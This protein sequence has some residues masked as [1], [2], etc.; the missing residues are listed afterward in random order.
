MRL[1]ESLRD[2]NDLTIGF[3]RSEIDGRTYGHRSKIPGFLYRAKH[4][5]VILIGIAEQFIMIQFYN[6]R[7]FM[8][9]FS[10]HHTEASN[11]ACYC[12]TAPL[13][14]QVN[15][16]TRIK[17]HR[18]CTKRGTGTVFNTLVDW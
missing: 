18:V 15:N 17:I 10:R 12:I 14:G 9:I 2:C 6:E 16:V 8:S 7:D 5:L 4:N 3:C 13:N 1:F 11:C